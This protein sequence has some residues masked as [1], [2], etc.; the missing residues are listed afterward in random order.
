M[1]NRPGEYRL[2]P[3]WWTA[4]LIAAIVAMIFVTMSLF[5]GSFRTYVP[6]TVTSDRAG[7]VMESGGK[8]KMR[9]VQV[10]RVER[11]SSSTDQVSL[12]LQIEP[13][14]IKFIPSNVEA[15]IRATS[16]F[17]AKYVDLV[18]PD[19]P[20]SSRLAAGAVLRSRNVTTEVN[21][22]F[23]NLVD[24]LHQID[25]AKL[26]AVLTALADGVRGQGER[27]GQATTDANTVLAELN[28]RNE[29][30][31]TDW[32]SLQAFSDTYG[33]A[34][35]DIVST[36]DAVSTSSATIS[37]HP[38]ALDALLL[39][40]IGL[41]KSGTALLEPN[42]QNFVDGINTLEPTT[43]LLH[44]YNPEYT[45][46]LVGAKWYLDNGGYDGAGG[47]DGRSTILDT[48]LLLGSDQY[49]YPDNLPIVNAKGGPGGKPG[50]GSLP[51][52]DK[53]FP[54]RYLVTDTGWGTGLDMRPNPGI[55]HPWWINYFPVTRAAPEPPGVLGIG[56]PAIGPVPHPDAPPYGAPQ[57][58]PD[59]APLYPGVP[60]APA[61]EPPPA[62]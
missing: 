59:G 34:A 62:P 26:N 42:R 16:V 8:V 40:T 58:G 18:Y 54:V 21:T 52:V 55:G 9:G 37:S 33:A 3:A 13:D 35:A 28:P 2:H 36:L 1:Q 39:N 19:Q 29:T 4:I 6:V 61:P 15:Q 32:Q 7:L 12:R 48:G 53:N 56:P 10:G 22:V 50:C 51:I 25:P 14:Q 27:I 24:L 46:M 23:G 11:I 41:S 47:I 43:T 31:R 5:S 49:R 17:G 20:S 44:K 38:D 30:L 60:P 57:Y 45:C